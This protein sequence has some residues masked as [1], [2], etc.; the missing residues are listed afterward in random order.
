MAERHV[1]DVLDW[2]CLVISSLDI[3]G[4][5]HI[6]EPFFMACHLV[7]GSRVNESHV[8]QLQGASQHRVLLVVHDKHRHHYN[9]VA[10][11]FRL[12]KASAV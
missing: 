12:D 3:A 4:L 1:S 2:V 11:L 7:G 6:L 5:S 10:L 9:V 8:F